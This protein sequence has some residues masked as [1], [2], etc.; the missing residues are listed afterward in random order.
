MQK[1]MTKIKDNKALVLTLILCLAMSSMCFASETTVEAPDFSPIIT[2][3][4]GVIS[5]T[6]LITIIAATIGVGAAFVLMWF[7]FRKLKAAFV[8]GFSKGKL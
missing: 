8:R 2:A 7:G 3:L 5:P 1:L 6:V 4:N